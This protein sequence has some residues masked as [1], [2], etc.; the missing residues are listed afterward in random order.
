MNK[1]LLYGTLVCAFP[2]FSQTTLF[3]DNFESGGSNWTVNGGTGD[4]QW[5][6]NNVFTGDD[7]GIVDPTPDQPAAVTA[8]P[9]SYY[10]HIYNTD[11]C[12]LLNGCNANFE[13]GS[14][15]DQK[16]QLSSAIVTTGYSNVT[17]SFYYLCAGAANVSFGTVEYS[18]D[19]T[20]WTDAGSTYV[21][22]GTWTAASL[23][24]PAWTNQAALKFRFRWQNGASGA[25]PAFAVDEVK[26]TGVAGSFAT[27]AT[28][29]A[30]PQIWCFSNAQALTVP[31]TATGTVNAGNVY[32][33]QLSNASG[34]FAAPVTIGTLTSSSTGALTINAVVPAGTPAGSGYRVRVN[35]SNPAATGTDNG[36]NL[37]I[38]PLPAIMVLSNPADGVMCVGE[39]VS[40]LANGANVVMWSWSPATGLSSTTTA[41]T[42]ATPAA[43]T[44]YTVTGTDAVGCNN[45]TTAVVT[46]ETCLGLDETSEASSLLLYP[47]PTSGNVTVNWK[48]SD[49]INTIQLMDYSGRL[50]EEIALQN[51]AFS[52]EA[53][54]AGTYFVQMVCNGQKYVERITRQ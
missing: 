54:P 33:A 52:L 7:F 37:T 50:L 27:V 46:V 26:V 8:G 35:A 18:T 19:G 34:S 11:L 13:T 3:Q 10:L 30:S 48:S 39:S 47:N 53:Y 29:M 36:S 6:V 24:L 51:D 22:T 31:F 9:N 4:N 28:G 12:D 23:T 49:V 32:T 14:T 45:L 44:T 25:D 38:S 40:L 16:A 5:I 21:N 17:L 20:T 2:S 1:I 15:S 42:T 41:A 43:T